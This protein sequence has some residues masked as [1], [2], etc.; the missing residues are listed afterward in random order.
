[1][2]GGDYQLVVQDENLCASDVSDESISILDEL[3]IVETN[4][5]VSNG[6]GTIEVF[7]SGGLEPY[8]YTL[9]PGSIEQK[10]N[11]VFIISEN[12]TYTIEVNDSL[13]CGPVM[14][15]ITTGIKDYLF[16]DALV[17]PNPSSGEVNIEIWTKASRSTIDVMSLTGQVVRSSVAYSSGGQIKTTLN[18]GDLAKGMYMLRVD[19]KMLRSAIVLQ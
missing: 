3:T 6:S 1:M 8:T 11:G 9:N 14:T 5:D 4:V 13:I 2:P 10:D 18:L 12:G 17:Y 19:G 16:I 15:E 7:V